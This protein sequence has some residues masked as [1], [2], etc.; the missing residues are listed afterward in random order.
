MTWKGNLVVFTL[1]IGMQEERSYPNNEYLMKEQ[2]LCT[3][4]HGIPLD[5]YFFAK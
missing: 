1:E 4:A 3:Y 5:I 2:V